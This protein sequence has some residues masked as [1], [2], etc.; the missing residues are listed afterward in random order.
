M[1]KEFKNF[2]VNLYYIKSDFN[3]IALR[4]CK[5]LTEKRCNYN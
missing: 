1:N 2:E 5:K 3:S 4:L